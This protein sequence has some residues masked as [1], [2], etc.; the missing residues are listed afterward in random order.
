MV[1][2]A[3]KATL[4][5]PTQ[6]SNKENKY[7][8]KIKYGPPPKDKLI[9]SILLITSITIIPSIR[10]IMLKIQNPKIT[11]LNMSLKDRHQPSILQEIVLSNLMMLFKL[12]K[13][14]NLHTE[15]DSI[16]SKLEL[17]I[18][19]LTIKVASANQ[20]PKEL[21]NQEYNQVKDQVFQ[22]NNFPKLCHTKTDLISMRLKQVF[23]ITDTTMDK[24]LAII[25]K[26]FLMKIVLNNLS[27]IILWN[28]VQINYGLKFQDTWDSNLQKYHLDRWNKKWK[29]ERMKTE[30]AK[31]YS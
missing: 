29:L 5:A 16:S 1:T 17:N 18:G 20:L 15:M 30:E 6:Q 3:I 21:Q 10:K 7:K 19:N 22:M 24:I 12:K 27:E 13:M 31:N 25:Q 4:N 8:T 23:P 26:K 2:E 11:I 14:D 28:T 9:N